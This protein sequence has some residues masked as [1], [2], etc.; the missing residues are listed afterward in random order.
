[1]DRENWAPLESNSAS[2]NYTYT[3]QSAECRESEKER[4]GKPELVISSSRH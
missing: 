4:G 3:Q 1:M 2:F